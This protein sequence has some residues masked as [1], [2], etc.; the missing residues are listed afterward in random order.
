MVE[1]QSYVK[2]AK[3]EITVWHTRA[4]TE[5]GFMPPPVVIEVSNADAALIAHKDK[6]A[7]EEIAEA[8]KEKKM[9]A[10]AAQE[11]GQ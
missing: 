3:K 11:E 1:L 5:P 4:T 7:A 8:E 10:M 2:A 9:A 6:M